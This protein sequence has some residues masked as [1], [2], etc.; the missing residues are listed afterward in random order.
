VRRSRA[1]ALRQSLG[2]FKA[3]DCM[4]ER[5]SA[6]ARSH[7]QHQTGWRRV[8]VSPCVKAATVQRDEAAG[9]ASP[10]RRSSR[11][12]IDTR[13][14]CIPVN[15]PVTRIISASTVNSSEISQTTRARASKAATPR[16]AARRT[17]LSSAPAWAGTP[18]LTVRPPVARA[19]GRRVRGR[20]RVS[21]SG[22]PHRAG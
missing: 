7:E 16:F 14:R 22:W 12:K 11:T 8:H 3:D 6:L 4:L 17:G 2:R 20:H 19:A 18:R 9:I 10:R 1:K 13:C 21:E 15:P 5:P